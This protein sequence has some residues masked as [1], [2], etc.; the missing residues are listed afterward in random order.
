MMA[1]YG[2][3]DLFRDAAAMADDDARDLVARLERRGRLADERAIRAAYLEMLAI[4]PGERVLDAGCG[5]G[6]VTR[7]LARRVSPGGRVVGLDPSPAFL[8]MARELA[9]EEGIEDAIEFREGDVRALPFADAGFDAVLAVTVLSHVEGGA[10]AV[11]ELARVV[12]PGGRIGVFDLDTDSLI[13]THPDRALTRRI[14]A[15]HSDGGA[16]DGWLARRLPGLFAEAGLVEVDVRAFTPLD[17]DPAGFYA[18]SAQRAA[19]TAARVG[20]ITEVERE[21]WL[22]ALAIERESGRFVAGRTHLF[23]WGRR[24]ALHRGP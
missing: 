7:D 5:S 9:R 10:R 22:G 14:V 2:Q 20:A 3:F 6:V 18:T 1:P 12:R 13:I 16:I 4:G 23:V 15:A 11:P 19:E 8:R 17:R 24:P 21:A